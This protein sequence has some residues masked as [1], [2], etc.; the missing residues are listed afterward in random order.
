MIAQFNRVLFFLSIL[1]VNTVSGQSSGS[2]PVEPENPRKVIPGQYIVVFRKSGGPSSRVQT[3]ADTRLRRQRMQEEVSATLRKNGI[4]ENKVLHIYETALQGFSVSGLTE[5]EAGQLRSDAGI[6]YIEPD[7]PVSASV[8]AQAVSTDV[9]EACA[10]PHVTFDGADNFNI[11][12]ASFGP[13][14]NAGGQLVLTD[15]ADACGDPTPA[16]F[17]PAGIT[18]PKIALIERGT[19]DFSL[20]AYKAQ[21]AGAVGVI[22]VNNVPGAPPALG[23]G[24]HANLVTI[25]VMSIAQEAAIAI[26]AAVS[27]GTAVMAGIYYGLPDNTFQC[28]PWGITRI[29]GG[30]PGGGKRAWIVDSG[31]DL[32]HPDLDVDLVNSASFVAG[33][34]SPDDE[35][36]HGTHVAGTLAALDN[37]QGVIGVAAGAKVVAVR[38]L[39]A[40]GNGTGASVI[41]GLNYVAGFPGLNA[42]DVVNVSLGGVP[43]KARE[44]AVV[45]LAG[46]CKVIIA[47]GNDTR[48]VNFMGPARVIHPNVYTVSAM[49]ASDTFAGFS[50]FGG[51][52][53]Y[54]APGVNILSCNR[55][56]GY[57]YRNGTS[58][59]A[60]HIAGLL[61]LGVDLCAS[62][63]V[64]G[65]KDGIPDAILT[66][67]TA[68]DNTDGDNDGFTPCEGDLDDNN[69]GIYPKTEICDGIDND[70]DGLIDE[71]DVCCPGSSSVLYVKAGAAGG[72]TGLSWSDAFTSLQPALAL[73]AK[74]S[75]IT[76]IWVA[77]GTYYPSTD[78]FGNTNPYWN[79]RTK[80]FS[81]GNNLALYGG[82]AGNEPSGF[83]LMQRDFNVNRTVLDG[84][85]Q[86][87][88]S[89]G[90]NAYHVIRNV[91]LYGQV[92]DNTTVI[93]GF[94][95]SGGNANMIAGDGTLIFP[96]SYGG[97]M[98]NYLAGPEIRNSVFE[99]N[100]AYEG[101]AMSNILSHVSI[102]Q[103]RINRNS[104]YYTAGIANDRSSP[105]ILNS[106]FQLNN[107][108]YDGAAMSNYT[109]SSPVVMNSSFSGNRVTNPGGGTIYNYDGSSPVIVNNIIWGNSAGI[110]NEPMLSGGA[111]STP[112]VSYSIVQELSAG[113]GPGNNLNSNPLFVSQ[114]V[115]GST[116][117]GDL[118]LQPCSP[119]LNAGDP[120]TTIAETGT[121]DIGGNTRIYGT[122]IDMGS[123]ELQRG[124]FAL[125]IS[126]DPGLSISSG[127]NVRL[128]ASGADSYTWTPSGTTASITVSPPATTVYTVTGVDGSCSGTAQVTV[129]VN[130]G[131]LPVSL[132]GFSARMQ[133]N[134]TVKL[135]WTTTAEKDNAYYELE[136]SADLKTVDKFARLDPLPAGDQLKKYGFIDEN[137]YKGR[138][139]YRLKQVDLDGNHIAY[140]WVSVF[141][142]GDN[143]IFPNP[144]T[145]SSF[146][147]KLAD[148]EKAVL[149][150]FTT[151]GR[152]VE[153]KVA[154]RENGALSLEI[155]ESLQPGVYVLS[156]EEPGQS[157]FHRVVVGK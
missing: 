40:A 21:L 38:V 22:I 114:P 60:P 131:P 77:K 118:S 54:C 47:A 45:A 100:Y 145:N 105:L 46:K 56:G 64:N 129:V 57:S 5:K 80:T 70:N 116:T 134:G 87:N 103:S 31:V 126:A 82:F 58:M 20:K 152:P 81:L 146:S 127:A 84:D 149:K 96:F 42:A 30:L 24:E 150:L 12:Q 18:G 17:F 68:G 121:T 2:G 4:S 111:A 50:N 6:E 115:I 3:I 53:R 94:V 110:F 148:P 136:K 9:S 69:P 104:G 153:I 108:E 10:S 39:N 15:P 79:V 89:A 65:D 122:V 154:G 97:G 27:G 130:G 140:P 155:A 141:A 16:T 85:I 63:R 92:M 59:A 128:T 117:L 29:G 75:S 157:S 151:E 123:N 99:S 43:S 107:T 143:R 26:K 83:D 55:G 44:D 32:D 125:S 120:N 91:P 74:C 119:A 137:P 109:G 102:K 142:G 34:P 36:G 124:P 61:L 19:C 88:A 144:V 106:S 33:A 73:A 25:P 1:F 133:S 93:D 86:Q 37:G 51:A 67:A 98:L 135:D 11:G 132:A 156:V 35:H 14:I 48:N 8:P 78:E 147:V 90:D 41:A 112:H 49:D 113:P 71:G 138:S 76:Q 7:V 139:Y 13:R 52:I 23:V 62:K 66:V 28:T 95:I 101:G 72:G